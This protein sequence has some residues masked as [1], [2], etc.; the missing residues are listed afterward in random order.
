[1]K[2][3]DGD[4]RKRKRGRS[5]RKGRAVGDTDSQKGQ[6]TCTGASR[7]NS[8][9]LAS[10]YH[11]P[12][13]PACTPRSPI[14]AEAEYRVTSS[15]YIHSRSR[16]LILPLGWHARDKHLSGAWRTRVKAS[17]DEGALSFGL[18][19]YVRTRCAVWPRRTHTSR[20]KNGQLYRVHVSSVSSAHKGLHEVIDSVTCASQHSASCLLK[21]D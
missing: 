8:S 12:P 11:T 21:L 1:M 7:Q 20:E 17:A 16:L 4:E 14:S 3:G 2:T 6:G 10:C 18:L 5:K 15:E 13:A 19:H 9:S